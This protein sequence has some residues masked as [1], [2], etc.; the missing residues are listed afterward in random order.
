MWPRLHSIT[1]GNGD[2]TLKKNQEAA[3]HR[4][5]LLLYA[6]YVCFRVFLNR[7]AAMRGGITANHKLSWL[8]IQVAPGTLLKRSDIF[9]E[10]TVLAGGASDN[11]LEDAI[12][13]EKLWIKEYLPQLPTLFCVLDEAQILSNDSTYFRSDEK[14]QPRPILREILRSWSWKLPDMIV[15]GTRIPMQGIEEAIGSVV[16]KEDDREMVTDL[17][18]FDDEGDQLAYL[19]RYFPPGFLDSSLG[20]GLTSRAGYWLRGR[21]VFSAAV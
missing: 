10:C 2:T 19:Q 5:L 21:F 9:L 12:L 7:A 4:S 16:A 8:L 3:R 15:S 20:E 11:Y 6:R 14:Q 18:G 13:R 17:G 1:D